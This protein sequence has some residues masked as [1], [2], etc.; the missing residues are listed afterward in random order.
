MA[1]IKSN[2]S[3][4]AFD[5]S[6]FKNRN[7][8]S[9]LTYLQSFEITTSAKRTNHKSLGKDE[10]IRKQFV[11][12]DVV[13]NLTFL[14]SNELTNEI[15]F[16]FNKILQ[17]ST[18][19]SFA[20]NFLIKKPLDSNGSNI[21]IF[22]NYS[23]F[24]IFNEKDSQDLLLKI[25]NEDFNED[26][27]TMSLGNLF[28]NSYSFS[29]DIN[30]LPVVSCSF[31]CSDLKLG[32]L[33]K[34]NS[35]FYVKNWD[36][37]EIPLLKSSVEN[38]LT[39]S[40]NSRDILVYVMKDFVFQ[41]NFSQTSTPGPCIDNF[42][43]GLIQSMDISIDFNRSEFYFFNKD[44][45]VSSRKINAPLTLRMKINGL[46]N[47]F[48]LGDVNTF[49]IQDQKF[50][51]SILMGDPLNPAASC[52]KLLFDN[53]CIENFNY[54]IDLNG[55]L[56]Y[57]IECYCEINSKSGFRILEI[58]KLDL[59]SIVFLTSDDNYLLSSDGITMVAKI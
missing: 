44:S 39:R 46:S 34:R 36:E 18:L 15:L 37:T 12:P 40:S 19:S 3:L 54:S 4:V 29:Y 55:M 24:A 9:F 5:T 20:E 25:N 48:E 26:M 43:D 31:L 49:F 17:E 57:S 30:E 10:L 33:Q 7:E 11:K 47:R 32:K 53:L 35:I 6:I 45:G 8:F 52:N 28:I 2:S 13:L 51:C 23:A 42:L 59:T 22:S 58:N 16:G 41:N 1:I 14:Q 56:N 27:I 38:L 21:D 50:S